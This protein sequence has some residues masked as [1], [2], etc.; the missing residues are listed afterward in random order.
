MD[1]SVVCLNIPIVMALEQRRGQGR[2]QCL[3]AVEAACRPIP[4]TEDL[5]IVLN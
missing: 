3:L 1:I 2:E 5:M 4:A